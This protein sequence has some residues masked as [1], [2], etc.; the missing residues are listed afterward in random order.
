MAQLLSNASAEWMIAGLGCIA[1]LLG[2]GVGIK[3]LFFDKGTM[4]SPQPLLIAMEKE[5]VNRHEY[6]RRHGDIE[7]QAK[8][9]RAYAHD[10]VHEIRGSL[11]EMKLS[12]EER[13]Q[14]LHKLDERT[15]THTRV[16][17]GMDQKIDHMADRMADKVEKLISNREHGSRS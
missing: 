6:E 16:L 7:N 2:I 15:Q 10:E 1:F 13:D 4:I 14:L 5:F 12:G 9:V 11:Q 17:S 8:D 3:K